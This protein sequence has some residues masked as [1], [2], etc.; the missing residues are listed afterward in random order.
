MVKF[1]LGKEWIK[2]RFLSPY[3]RNTLWDLGYALDTLE[4]ALPWDRLEKGREEILKAI[5]TGWRIKMKSSSS[6][7]MSPMF[8][9]TAVRCM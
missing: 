7:V 9:P 4:T 3:L 6:S 2:K 1:Y 8:T 5:R